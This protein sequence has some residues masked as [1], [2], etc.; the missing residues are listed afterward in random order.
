MRKFRSVLI[1]PVEENV[2]KNLTCFACHT[3]TKCELMII[4]KVPGTT[5]FSGLHKDCFEY[6]NKQSVKK[7]IES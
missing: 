6:L 1:L 4:T 2:D 5:I 7:I 3:R